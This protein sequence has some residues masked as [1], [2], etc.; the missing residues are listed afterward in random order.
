MYTTTIPSEKTNL[1]YILCHSHADNITK[2][3]IIL[4]IKSPE[5]NDYHVTSK[6]SKFYNLRTKMSCISW[7]ANCVLQNSFFEIITC[8][9]SSPVA[10][11]LF[12]YRNRRPF[13]AGIKIQSHENLL[14]LFQC[15]N[16]C[17]R[18]RRVR[19]SLRFL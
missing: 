6:Y 11:R 5:L 4:N 7:S 13:Q 3:N 17:L 2:K 10:V 1:M 15:R 8:T 14:N 18:G 12:T 16:L 9:S 19:A